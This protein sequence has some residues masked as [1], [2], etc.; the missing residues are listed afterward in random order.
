MWTVFQSGNL[1]RGYLTHI[2][3]T[4]CKKTLPQL[5]EVGKMTERDDFR[6]FA[7]TRLSRLQPAERDIHQ[8]TISLHDADARLAPA[9]PTCCLPDFR[10]RPDWK[11]TYPLKFGWEGTK[12]KSFIGQLFQAT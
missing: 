10:Q 12:G 4:P 11:R 8:T 7:G 3:S 6:L 1:P 9:S 5:T 2:D